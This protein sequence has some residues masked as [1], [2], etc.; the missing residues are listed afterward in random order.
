MRK[1][2][3]P[4]IEHILIAITKI[5][6]YT[7]GMD[8]T[9]FATN[10]LVQDG[11]VR[12]LEIIG[13][14]CSNLEDNFRATYPTIPWSQI[15]GMRNKLAHEYWDIDLGVVWTTITTEILDLENELENILV[16]LPAAT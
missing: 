11:V 10:T 4:Y 16:E 13:E 15:V 2:P 12:Q 9:S 7:K 5:K 6:E 14:A 8:Q 1:N 3:K